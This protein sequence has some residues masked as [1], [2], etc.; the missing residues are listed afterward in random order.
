M[1][2]PIVLFTAF[3]FGGA[4]P[5]PYNDAQQ[6]TAEEARALIAPGRWAC[7]ETTWLPFEGEEELAVANFSYRFDGN[8]LSTLHAETSMGVVRERRYADVAMW[9]TPLKFLGRYFDIEKGRTLPELLSDASDVR[10]RDGDVPGSRVV[11][12]FLVSSGRVWLI[13][14]QVDPSRGFAPTRIALYDGLIGRPADVIQIDRLERHADCWIPVEGVETVYYL[15]PETMKGELWERYADGMAAL[16]PPG[17][18]PDATVPA[19]REAVRRLIRDVYGPGGI[20]TAEL[21]P[22]HRLTVTIERV[23]EPIPPK[24]F[25]LV[26]PPD[27][28]IVDWL[29]GRASNGVPVLISP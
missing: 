4:A 26:L 11:S 29:R 23:N 14:A 3:G 28:V 7:D 17:E 1:I 9:A 24:E 22:P 21:A 2:T 10:V 18:S 15:D 5:P 19:V 25:E 27:A 8:A 13:E 20:P 6:G 16:A 12:G